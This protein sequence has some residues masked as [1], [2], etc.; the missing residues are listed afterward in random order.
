MES[1]ILVCVYD[2]TLSNGN[3]TKIFINGVDSTDSDSTTATSLVNAN[4]PL[5]IGRRDQTPTYYY[6]GFMDELAMWSGTDQ[7]ANVS[8]IYGGGQAVDLNTLPTVP[9]P[10][11]WQRM[12]KEAIW[13]GQT[14]I[15]VDVNGGYTNRSINMVEANRTT[16]VPPNP[17]VNLQSI[18]LD[19]VDD[20]VEIG[21][22]TSIQNLTSEITISAWVK[23]P[24][25]FLINQY[26]LASK[27]EYGAPGAQWNIQMYTANASNTNGADIFKYSHNQMV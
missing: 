16:D 3:K 14:W 27:G 10:T 6:D 7:R 15:M 24:K 5:S 18:L 4:Y 8:E 26:A 23:A 25:T 20:Y 1:H 17:F 21:S 22:P 2:G 19:G 11:T 9:P 13:N 12:G